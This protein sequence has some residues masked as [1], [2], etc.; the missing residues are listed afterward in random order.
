MTDRAGSERDLYLDVLSILEAAD[1]TEPWKRVLAGLVSQT[2]AESAYVEL[3]PES[4]AGERVWTLFH[5]CSAGDRERI[6]AATSRGPIAASMA[7]GS[8]VHTPF[9]RLDV[10]VPASQNI[11]WVVLCVPLAGG[12]SGALYLEG[13]PAGGAFPPEAVQTVENVARFL[14]TALRG[15]TLAGPVNTEDP[16]L[17]FR[18]RLRVD[19]FVGHSHALARVFEQVELAAARDDTVLIRGPLATGK[20]ALARVIHE[21]SARKEGPFVEVDFITVPGDLIHGVLYGPSR[22]L[23]SRTYEKGKVEEAEGGTLFLDDIATVPLYWQGILL[24]LLEPQG[25]KPNRRVIAATHANLEELVAA[26]QFR[27]DLFLRLSGF[28]LHLPS[29]AERREDIRDLMDSLLGT[30]AEKRALPQLRPSRGL[31]ELCETSDWPG[32]VRQ[33]RNELEAALLQASREGTA[34]IE[35]RHLADGRRLREVSR[36]SFYE[37]TRQFQQ[38]LLR[39]EL[40]AN[41]W[42]VIE[43]ARK[44]DL[45]RS[46]LYNLI[47]TL[48]LTRP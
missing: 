21:H 31:Y 41:D 29:L 35:P 23:L 34:F 3:H 16:T 14:D 42:N 4:S 39:R 6:R 38:D 18:R 36:T 2:G 11:P 46:H 30:L 8:T 40:K 22:R 28:T 15:R 5:G 44:L 7:S 12:A 33:L 27:Q 19:A 9:A 37:E 32:N 48:G 47:Q 25:A 45:P 24:R 20:T 13:Q 10:P 17:P 43:V 26:G 1:T